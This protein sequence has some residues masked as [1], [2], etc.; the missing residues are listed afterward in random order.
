M[1]TGKGSMGSE[2]SAVP[3]G[4][5]IGARVRTHFNRYTSSH[6][7]SLNIREKTDTQSEKKSDSETA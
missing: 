6:S 1:A 4:M 7:P 2:E 3:R 5:A